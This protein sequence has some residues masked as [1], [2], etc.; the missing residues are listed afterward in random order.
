MI[1]PLNKD[2]KEEILLT[3][4]ILNKIKKRNK[5]KSKRKKFLRNRQTN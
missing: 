5:I 1:S 4:L 3:Q 2:I